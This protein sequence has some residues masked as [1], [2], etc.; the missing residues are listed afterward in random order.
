MRTQDK[1]I[2]EELPFKA[3]RF[4]IFNGVGAIL[5][6]LNPELGISLTVGASA[7]DEFFLEKLG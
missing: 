7:F 4:F 1:S 5:T 2:L 6:A 3:A